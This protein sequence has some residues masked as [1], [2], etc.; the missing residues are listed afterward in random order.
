MQI[1]PHSQPEANENQSQVKAAYPILPKELM[2]HIILHA[3]KK[4]AVYI[5]DLMLDS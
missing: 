4:P 3:I 1:L 2:A 5:F